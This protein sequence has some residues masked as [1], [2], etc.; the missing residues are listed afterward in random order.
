MDAERVTVLLNYGDQALLITPDHDADNPLRVP[1][2][3][4]AR[5][6]GLPAGELPGRTFTARRTAGGYADYRLAHDPRL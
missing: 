2:A 6:A 4:I 1:A 5:D 3:D